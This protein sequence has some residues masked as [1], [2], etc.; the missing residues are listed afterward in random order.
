M[1]TDESFVVIEKDHAPIIIEDLDSNTFYEAY[2]VAVNTHGRGNIKIFY[3]KLFNQLFLLNNR[4]INRPAIV[5]FSFQ[6]E[7]TSKRAYNAKI[8]LK[9]VK[10]IIIHSIIM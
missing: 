1:N 9:S 8:C 5:A 2:V 6:N 7:T 3:I 4:L 10:R